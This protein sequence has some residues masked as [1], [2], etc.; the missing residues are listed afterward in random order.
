MNFAGVTC[1]VW[2]GFA[3][4]CKILSVRSV[5]KAGTRVAPTGIS[6]GE[7][8]ISEL[9]FQEELGTRWGPSRSKD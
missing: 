1:L 3:A 7:N 9:N 8:R 5:P 2:V 6:F 4:H